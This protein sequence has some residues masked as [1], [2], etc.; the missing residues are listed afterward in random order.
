MLHEGAIVAERYGDGVEAHEPHLLMSVTKSF[1]GS[2]TGI[3]VERG[4]LSPDMVVT[5]DHAGGRRL[6]L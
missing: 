1:A 5:D 4:L 2:L 6:G 3:L